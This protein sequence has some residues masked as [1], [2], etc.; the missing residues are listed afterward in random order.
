[1]NH[2]NEKPGIKVQDV[3]SLV[4]KLKNEA[5]NIMTIL[6]VIEHDNNTIKQS[7]LSTI[8]AAKK[9]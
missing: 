1:M 7:S 4:N 9:N 5:K 8:S 2:L 3:E 6:V